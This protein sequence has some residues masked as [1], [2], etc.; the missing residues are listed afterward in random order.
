MSPRRLIHLLACAGLLA[1]GAFAPAALPVQ[2]AG[3]AK[4]APAVVTQMSLDDLSRMLDAG[5]YAPKRAQ[6]E[7]KLR[8]KIEGLNVLFFVSKD[9]QSMQAYLGFRQDERTSLE[10]MNDWNKTHRFSRAYLD[11]DGDP[12]LELDLDLAGGVTPARIE[13]YLLT[14]KVSVVAFQKFLNGSE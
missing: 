13:D 14:V 7:D 12:C 2:E 10:Q 3:K 1:G 4:T 11:G 6:D 5:G 8:V 9:R